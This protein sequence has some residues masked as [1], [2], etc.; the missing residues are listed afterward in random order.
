MAELARVI[1]GH[2]DIT[3]GALTG[4]Y[5]VCLALAIDRRRAAYEFLPQLLSALPPAVPSMLARKVMQELPNT[6]A[7]LISLPRM[8]SNTNTNDITINTIDCNYLFA[9][10]RLEAFYTSSS[11]SGGPTST[12]ESNVTLP[13]L[14]TR[15]DGYLSLIACLYRLVPGT[16]IPTMEALKKLAVDCLT[17]L[18]AATDPHR[19]SATTA[20]ESVV[21]YLL[22]EQSISSI[23][24]TT[25]TTTTT[26][27]S[28]SSNHDKSRVLLPFQ[29]DQV[30]MISNILKSMQE[31]VALLRRI[32]RIP[33]SSGINGKVLLRS[34]IS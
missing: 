17:T 3:P 29:H 23:S 1:A 34:G 2:D 4:I 24:T 19:M 11:S 12:N 27:I 14:M 33:D 22:H 20:I 18:V 6:A 9:A 30:E 28:A 15:P 10:A 32:S 16:N 25:A 26:P 8:D 21:Q 13:H 5:D 31:D 7:G